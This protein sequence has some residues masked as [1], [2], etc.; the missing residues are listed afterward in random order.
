MKKATDGGA[1]GAKDTVE[2]DWGFR[3]VAPS[4]LR[5]A[6]GTF[7]DDDFADCFRGD[8]CLFAFMICVARLLQ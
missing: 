7:A 8:E 6:S 2:G 5:G 3:H 4:Y 1:T